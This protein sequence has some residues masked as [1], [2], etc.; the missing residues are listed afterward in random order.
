MATLWFEVQGSTDRLVNSNQ[1]FDTDGY[2][3]PQQWSLVLRSIQILLEDIPE[4]Y[5][6]LKHIA[7]QDTNEV[8]IFEYHNLWR[9]HRDQ[10]LRWAKTLWTR[11]WV[12]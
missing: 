2:V 10:K 11:S 9:V 5:S 12:I 1:V 6:R 4:G 7:I 3:M 8:R